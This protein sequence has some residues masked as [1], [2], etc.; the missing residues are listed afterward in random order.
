M[1]EH[2][3]NL[4]DA[5]DGVIV[6]DIHISQNIRQNVK[7]IRCNSVSPEFL[8]CRQCSELFS[9]GVCKNEVESIKKKM[10]RT[11]SQ[12]LT[13]LVEKHLDR[14]CEKCIS[15]YTEDND[16]QGLN[17]VLQ[18]RQVLFTLC[19]TLFGED[20]YVWPKI[21]NNEWAPFRYEMLKEHEFFSTSLADMGEIL[22][23]P[24][25]S[26]PS[27][28]KIHQVYSLFEYL[29]Q[30]LTNLQELMWKSFANFK[31][32]ERKKGKHVPFQPNFEFDGRY[33]LTLQYSKSYDDQFR[34]E[35][36]SFF[37]SPIILNSNG[38]ASERLPYSEAKEILSKQGWTFDFEIGV[39]ELTY[40]NIPTIILCFFKH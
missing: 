2:L 39:G 26:G 14:T 40:R 36:D 27:L 8:S 25:Q 5:R 7:C 38:T 18:L 30:R 16:L 22:P 4:V 9:C 11:Y 6:G 13:K 1:A 33:L 37:N 24:L 10:F 23:K 28:A 29:N 20:N 17:E 31:S 21:E 34:L 19:D 32:V 15:N 12:T 35:M 3:D